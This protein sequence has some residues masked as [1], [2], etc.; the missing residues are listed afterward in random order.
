MNP[1]TALLSQKTCV[2]LLVA[3]FNKKQALEG[4]KH[5]ARLLLNA[6]T[7]SPTC[8]GA[9][10]GMWI[11]QS[12]PIF[13]MSLTFHLVVVNCGSGGEFAGFTWW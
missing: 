10:G 9:G 8:G 1:V 4:R 5:F 7:E 11:P 12:S 13:K 2:N 6:Y 3:L